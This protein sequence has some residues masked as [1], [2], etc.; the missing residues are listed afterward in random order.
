MH[1][2][3]DIG[4]IHSFLKCRMNSGLPRLIFPSTKAIIIENIFE[5]EKGENFNS[6]FARNILF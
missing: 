1:H 2:N 3:L 5:D 6:F 4:A